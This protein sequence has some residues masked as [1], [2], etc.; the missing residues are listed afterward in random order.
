MN[1][2]VIS[3]QPAPSSSPEAVAPA[4]HTIAILVV[5]SALTVLS[6]RSGNLVGLGP[7]GRAGSYGMV[8]VFEWATVAFIWYGVS[9]RGLRIADLVGGRWSGPLAVLRDL[10]IAIVYL[11]GSLLILNLIGYVLK[12]APNQA[13]RNIFPHGPTEIVLYL[14]LAATAGFCEELIFRGYLQRQFSAW[15][16]SAIGGIVLQGIAFGAAHGYQGWKYMVIIAVFG[17]MFGLLA[18]WLRSLRPGMMAHFVQDGVGGLL[19]PHFMK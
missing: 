10:G 19:G 6:A 9:R 8:M 12:A 11:M 2:S 17:T 7:Y 16:R 18:Q 5:M 1:A 3:A 14:M 15:T 4:W 13:I